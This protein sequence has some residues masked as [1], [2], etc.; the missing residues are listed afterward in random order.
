MSS[1][2]SCCTTLAPKTCGSANERPRRAPP[3]PASRSGRPGRTAHRPAGRRDRSSVHC[4][5]ACALLTPRRRHEQPAA[6][7]GQHDEEDQVPGE[8]RVLRIDRAPIVWATPSTMPP[9]QRAPQRAEAADDDGLEGEDE[10][11]RSAGRV[12]ARVDGQERAGQRRGADRDRGGPGVHRR[13]R[14]ADQPGGVRILRGGPH[15]PA[16]RGAAQQQLE[17]AEHGHRDRQHEQPEVRD[18]ELVGDPPAA[19]ADRARR[20]P[21]ASARPG[22]KICS[23]AFWITIASPNVVSSGVSSPARRLRASSVTCST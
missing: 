9:T 20:P 17:P 2:V 21:R 23:S 1:V 12:E 6:G 4:G 18:G 8:D 13:G 16:E 3:G 22:E 19:D 15:L 11:G 7:T 10:L 14:H 5:H